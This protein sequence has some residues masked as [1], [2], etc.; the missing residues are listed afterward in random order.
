MSELDIQ[1]Q[2]KLIRR[3]G[4]TEVLTTPGVCEGPREPLSDDM[5]NCVLFSGFLS[6]L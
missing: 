1:G 2:R 5:Q 3:Q 6:G 4:R